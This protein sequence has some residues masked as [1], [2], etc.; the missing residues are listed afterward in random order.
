MISMI[1]LKEIWKGISS[2]RASHETIN[3][4]R[5]VTMN[6][7]IA[8]R[9]VWIAPLIFSSFP[10]ERMNEIPHTIMKIKL[11]I[12]AAIIA[13]AINVATRS[14]MDP[15]SRSSRIIDVRMRG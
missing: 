8:N 13:S 15:C 14:T 5:N 7:I 4:A 1:M 10:A 12:N 3:V 2:R 9:I 6:P 11:R